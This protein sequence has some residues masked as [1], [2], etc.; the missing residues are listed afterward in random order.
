MNWTGIGI[1]GKG[2]K[3][4]IA[5]PQEIMLN[6]AD[7]QSLFNSI[8]IM[9]SIMNN[10]SPFLLKFTPFQKSSS[11]S[12]GDTYGDIKINFHIDKMNGDK[13]DLHRFSKMIDD[14][15]LRRKGMRK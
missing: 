8:N 2:G 1:D 15:L 13:N 4:I 11:V 10:L 7:T 9:D 5:H 6:K 12:T 3:A 14:D